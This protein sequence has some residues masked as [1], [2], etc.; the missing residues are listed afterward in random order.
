MSADPSQAH[1]ARF[2]F[3]ESHERL[4][5]ARQYRPRVGHGYRVVRWYPSLFPLMPR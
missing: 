5:S 1:P 4:A 3:L 2:F